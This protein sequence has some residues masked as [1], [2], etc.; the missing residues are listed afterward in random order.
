MQLDDPCV[1]G[2]G[3]KFQ[4]CCQG[5]SQMDVIRKTKK[6]FFANL[7]REASIKKC[8]YPDTSECSEKVIRAHS[9]QNNRILTALSEDGEVFMIKPSYNEEVS[10]L[11]RVGRGAATTFTGFCGKH[12]K[13]VFA[14][15][16]DR[17]YEPGNREQEALFAFRALSKE[18]HSKLVVNKVMEVIGIPHP[19][20]MAL[21]FG[22][23]LG[24]KDLEKDALLF[25]D[26]LL[27]RQ[28]EEIQTT[29]LVLDTPCEIA[30]SSAVTLP[31]DFEGKELPHFK[32]QDWVNPEILFITIFP[33]EGKTYALFSYGAAST[34]TFRFLETQLLSKESAS[35]RELLTRLVVHNCENLVLSPRLLKRKGKEF[36]EQLISEFRKA[37]TL[38][39]GESLLDKKISFSLFE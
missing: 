4:G 24:L 37:I 21:Q 27:G 11:E 26:I 18:W 1:C 34:D 39:V 15:I 30:V 8:L 5:L 10:E 17:I 7:M 29:R 35:L 16:E 2:S 19:A 33:Q 9:L 28:F 38:T 22:N 23:E 25:R 32:G 20:L 13:E 36:E 14:P 31:Y 3:S 12:D 6:I